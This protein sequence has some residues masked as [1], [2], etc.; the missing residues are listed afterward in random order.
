MKSRKGF[1]LIELLVVIA[2]IAIL[3]AILFPV[4]ARAREKARQTSCLSNLKQMGL[5]EHMYLN[6]WDDK[7]CFCTMVTGPV[8]NWYYQ[9]YYPDDPSRTLAYVFWPDQLQPYVKNKQIFDC[10]SRP[11]C[12]LSYSRNIALGYFGGFDGRPGPWYEGVKLATILHPSEMLLTIDRHEGT[13]AWY[14][15]RI[16]WPGSVY[17]Q[18][19]ESCFPPLHNEGHNVLLVDGHAKWYRSYRYFDKGVGGVIIW[20][21]N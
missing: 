6:D 11:Y 5:A 10:P 3:A 15:C 9:Y 20:N 1:T 16:G 12:W 8:W 13:S 2:I 14:W 4:F 21:I 7:F 19:T 18:P 17:G